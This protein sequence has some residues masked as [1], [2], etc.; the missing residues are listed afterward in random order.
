MA[1]KQQCQKSHVAD[2]PDYPFRSNYLR[3]QKGTGDIFINA[4]AVQKMLIDAGLLKQAAAL[5]V[6]MAGIIKEE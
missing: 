4:Y 3:Y 1:R 6:R 5:T 2:V